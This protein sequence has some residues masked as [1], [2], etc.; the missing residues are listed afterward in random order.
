M[1]KP[2]LI[3]SINIGLRLFFLSFLYNKQSNPNSKKIANPERLKLKSV[4]LYVNELPKDKT[5]LIK[6]NKAVDKI[7]EI[8]TGLTP[9]NPPC[10]KRFLRILLI[11]IATNKMMIKEG[12]ITPIV[13]HIEPNIPPT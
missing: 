6:K 1:P 11:I 12:K 8:T 7:K 5:I 2:A 4:D 10:T 13:A 9:F 3:A